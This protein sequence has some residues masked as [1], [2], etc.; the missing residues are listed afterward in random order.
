MG[1]AQ[2]AAPFVTET[3]LESHRDTG[4]DLPANRAVRPRASLPSIAC[5]VRDLREPCDVEQVVLVRDA[6][7]RRRRDGGEYLRLTLGDRTGTIAAVAWDD[8]AAIAPRARAP[9]S[10]VWVCGRFAVHQRYGPQLVLA[11]VRPARE[12]EYGPAD[13]LDGPPRAVAS[14]EA[15]L[16]ELIA[17]VRNPWL[18][19]LLD[20][21]LGE[22]L[23]ACGRTTASRP[24]PSTTTRPTATACSSTR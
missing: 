5:F 9:G 22:R 2:P 24:R 12:G 4:R 17:T 20:R 18:Q 3:Q 7:L 21:V 19:R 11:A 15:D 8:A 13:V 16:R 23:G 10:V 1:W 6:E 14:M